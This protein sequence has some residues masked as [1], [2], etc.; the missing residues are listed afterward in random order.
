VAA[1]LIFIAAN[2]IVKPI[3]KAVAGLKDI[4]QGE[5]DL[6]MRLAVTSKDEVGELAN[7]STPSS[8]SCKQ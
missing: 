6:T 5:G 3:N 8:T 1:L 7:G 4:A 2:S